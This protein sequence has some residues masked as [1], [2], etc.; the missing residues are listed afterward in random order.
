MNKIQIK[1]LYK[2]VKDGWT[3]RGESHFRTYSSAER[4]INS[5]VKKG[6]LVKEDKGDP[7]YLTKYF[8]TVAAR[9]YVAFAHVFF[10]DKNE[11]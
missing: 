7:Q 6:F 8:P 9:E 3:Y 4:A 1:T 5:L 10:G 2:A 11:S